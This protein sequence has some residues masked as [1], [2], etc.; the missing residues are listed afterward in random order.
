MVGWEEDGFRGFGSA[1]D[2][3]RVGVE[4][5]DGRQML[6]FGGVEFGVG[7]VMSGRDAAEGEFLGVE[8]A[9]IGRSGRFRRGG[10]WFW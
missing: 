1:F 4:D 3:A 6:K 8:V 9:E 5:F 7:G 2:S 10:S